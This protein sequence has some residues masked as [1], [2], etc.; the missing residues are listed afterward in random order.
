MDTDA[1]PCRPTPLHWTGPFKVR[2]IVTPARLRRARD[3]CPLSRP[4]LLLVW[5]SVMTCFQRC[6][7]ASPWGLT[8]QPEGDKSPFIADCY[9]FPTG[10]VQGHAAVQYKAW[11]PVPTP[12]R[13]KAVSGPG[14]ILVGQSSWLG[15]AGRPG[16]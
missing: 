14:P 12:P 5:R 7:T 15:G 1:P 6:G 9:N 8:N 13:A 16:C 11:G 2:C 10:P 4:V 3:S